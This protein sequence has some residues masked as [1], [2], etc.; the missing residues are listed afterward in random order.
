MYEWGEFMETL[1]NKTVDFQTIMSQ[2]LK[3]TSLKVQRLEDEANSKYAYAGNSS[4]SAPHPRNRMM[5]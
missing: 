3:E 2:A 1:K 5:I 4:T